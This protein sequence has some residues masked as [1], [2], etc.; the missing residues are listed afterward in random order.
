M[1]HFL[2]LHGRRNRLTYALALLVLAPLQQ[3]RGLLKL[4]QQVLL[5]HLDDLFQG[6][7]QDIAAGV[8]V[9]G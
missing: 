3:F 6:R 9:E 5:E 2:C 1:H 7:L 8:L 4:R